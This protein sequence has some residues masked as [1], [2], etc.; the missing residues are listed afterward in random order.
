[1]WRNVTERKEAE[2]IYMARQEALCTEFYS[3]CDGNFA[4]VIY[5]HATVQPVARLTTV[6]VSKYREYNMYEP[7]TECTVLQKRDLLELQVPT[8]IKWDT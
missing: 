5:W 4:G 2:N 6:M 1:M 3:K 8:C 7:T